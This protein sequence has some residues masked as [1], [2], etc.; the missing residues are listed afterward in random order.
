M[1][2]NPDDFEKEL[3]FRALVRMI[4]T[5]SG[6]GFH[7]ADQGHP[8][9][10]AGANGVESRTWGDTAERNRLYR[11]LTSFPPQHHE[12]GPDLSNWQKFCSF[13]VEAYNRAK[14][15]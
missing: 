10:V 11:L 13:A 1:I 9:Y 7:N 15:R 12:E 4:E 3:I 14:G 2:D 8:A 5:N 6:T